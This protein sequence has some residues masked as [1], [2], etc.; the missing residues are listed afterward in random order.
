MMPLAFCA[1]MVSHAFGEIRVGGSALPATTRRTVNT[2]PAR[3]A[4]GAFYN[5]P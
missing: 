4:A 3:I 5:L 2:L 1:M